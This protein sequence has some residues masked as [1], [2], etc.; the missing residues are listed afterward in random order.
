MAF[1]QSNNLLG[2]VIYVDLLNEFPNWHG[3][4]WLKKELDKRSDIKQFKLDNPGANLPN[5]KANKKNENLLKQMFYNDFV[6]ATIKPLK[7][8]YSDLDFLPKKGK[9]QFM[10]LP[11]STL[12]RITLAIMFPANGEFYRHSICNYP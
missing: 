5:I 2:N 4:D 7:E 8:K 10:A 6:N 12:C 3:Y 1:L 9:G 11:K